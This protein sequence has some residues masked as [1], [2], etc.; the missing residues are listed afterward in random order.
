M[1]AEPRPRPGPTVA[2]RPIRPAD[3]GRVGGIV[4]AAYDAVGPFD[5]PYRV[6]LADPGNWVP[7]STTTYVAELDGEV[8]GAVAFVLP[9]DAEFENLRPPAGDCGFRF[10]AVAPEAQGSGAG[11][12][13]VDR[14]IEDARARGCHRML[15]HS[16][17]FMTAAHRLYERRGF[18]R[19]PDLD[20]TFPSGI[21]YAFS[22]DL[23]E[24]ASSRFP[25]PGPVPDE[26]PWYEELW[27]QDED[28]PPVC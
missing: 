18:V 25:P 8:V 10:L 13:L 3:R 27:I 28:D 26:P 16:M 6:F 5:E 23:T 24:E 1:T 22:L 7:G 4:L 15:I 21:G 20:V 12:E 17:A 11:A 2:V 19:R 14:V 9:G